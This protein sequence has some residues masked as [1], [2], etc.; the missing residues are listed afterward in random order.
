MMWIITASCQFGRGCSGYVHVKGL[1]QG[2]CHDPIQMFQLFREVFL[3]QFQN[4]K[5]L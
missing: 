4:I 3:Q 1:Y 5:V 2:I